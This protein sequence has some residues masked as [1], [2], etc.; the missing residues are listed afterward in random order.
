[1]K[2]KIF[3]FEYGGCAQAAVVHGPTHANKINEWIGLEPN[4]DKVGSSASEIGIK[5]PSHGQMRCPQMTPL[6]KAYSR[7]RRQ[8]T[9]TSLQSFQKCLWKRRLLTTGP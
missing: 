6:F 2:P 9:P 1:V 3:L 8:Y 7:K 4:K 5:T